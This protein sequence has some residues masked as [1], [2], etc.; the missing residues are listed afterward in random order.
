MNDLFVGLRVGFIWAVALI[1]ISGCSESKTVDY[2]YNHQLEAREKVK[3]CKNEEGGLQS[4]ETCMNA[5]Q[6]VKKWVNTMNAN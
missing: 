6:A 3:E 4:S 5:L 2:Y 1:F